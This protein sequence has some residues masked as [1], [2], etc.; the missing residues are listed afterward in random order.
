MARRKLPE[1]L[2]EIVHAI[3]WSNARLQ[4]AQGIEKPSLLRVELARLG[5]ANEKMREVIGE[6]FDGLPEAL[7]LEVRVVE[8]GFNKLDQ[9]L[10]TRKP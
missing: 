8:M 4:S 6:A 10:K 9:K 2:E 7:K 3:A 1:N 5:R